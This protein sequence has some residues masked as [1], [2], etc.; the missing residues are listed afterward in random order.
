V[1]FTRVPLLD[2][3]EGWGVFGDG[4][5]NPAAFD[6]GALDGLAK[7]DQI[8]RRRYGNQYV[9]VAGENTAAFIAIASCLQRQRQAD[10]LV[11]QRQP[12]IGV[13]DDPGRIAET[14]CRSR[15]G[16][17]REVDADTGDRV[18]ALQHAKRVTRPAPEIDDDIPLSR[19]ERGRALDERV[20]HG[21][22]DAR[23][24]QPCPCFH[25]LAAV[26]RRRRSAVLGLQQIDVA[27]AGDVE[28]MMSCAGPCLPRA[29]QRQVA[30]ANGTGQGRRQTDI[31]KRTP[32]RVLRCPRLSRDAS[33][34]TLGRDQLVTAI[35]D[36]LA[37]QDP[38][39]LAEMRSAVIAEIDGAPN[40]ALVSLA[41]RLAAAGEDWTYYES[42]PV[43]RRLHHVLADHILKPGSR[44][45]GID[46][47]RAVTGKPVVIFANHLS[48]ADANLVEVLLHRAGG[49]DLAHRLTVIAGP[50]VYSSLKRRFSSLCF[51]TIKT[52]QSSGVASEDAVMNAREVV[53]AARQSIDIAQDRLRRG[54]ALLV[55]AEGTRSRNKGLQ[56]MLSGV[57]RYI[58]GDGISI[59]P[60]GI[61]GTE[62]LFPVG[63]DTLHPVEAVARVGE[64]IDAT[65]LREH[66]HGDRRL[67]MDVVGLAIAGL[68]PDDYKGVYA[69]DV[70]GLDEARSV[71][72]IVHG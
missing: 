70:E 62:E 26:T 35:T 25:R 44:L 3:F 29:F 8:V 14:T 55:F 66:S 19:E 68:L 45:E 15:C 65:S 37:N 56:Q 67:M 48:Y 47:V 38:A 13:R 31:L 10:T 52:P 16:Y 60:V 59:L 53:R 20:E 1:L 41:R 61:T 11:D 69:P 27:G 39:A 34:V 72:G 17:R 49:D 71:L 4:I 36:F 63:D 54:D 50:K 43:A 21:A 7:F 6:A 18:H 23:G 9:A 33:R 30:Q 40:T 5:R 46:H 42:D 22:T 24:E 57:S 32:T 51:A 58:D 12:S 28:G 2:H 64:P